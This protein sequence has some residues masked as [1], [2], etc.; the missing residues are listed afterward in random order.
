MLFQLGQPKDFHV[1][2]NMVLNVI[3]VTYYYRKKVKKNSI[4][5]YNI[6]KLKILN[7]TKLSPKKL[8]QTK[9]HI[10]EKAL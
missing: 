2:Q 1:I 6:Q 8:V 4:T 3:F 5:I 9:E 7:S 10:P